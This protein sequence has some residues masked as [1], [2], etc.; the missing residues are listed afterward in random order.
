MNQYQERIDDPRYRTGA[1]RWLL[2]ASA[3]IL[4]STAA[5][6][7]STPPPATAG[8]W[9]ITLFG[10]GWNSITVPYVYKTPSATS[11]VGLSNAPTFGLAAGVDANRL[12][13]IEALWMQANPA[14]QYTGSPPTEIRTVIMN[15]F[16]ADSLWY[17]KRGTLQ[18]Y[19]VFGLGASC[20]G[21]FGGTN[22]M[23]VVGAGVKA[24]LS[25]HFA[26]RADVRWLNIY[27]KRDPAFCDS[28]GCYFYRGSWYS[29]L[30]VTAGL[31]YAF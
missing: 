27:G 30:P 4:V 9:Q 3:L 22:F 31:T 21:S 19:G 24:F 14:Q 13:G 15:N 29:S 2:V 25:P 26:I 5:R 11:E 23:V 12:L 10:G 1:R 17:L 8:P 7:Q 18:P 28:A 6:A 16:E 20:T